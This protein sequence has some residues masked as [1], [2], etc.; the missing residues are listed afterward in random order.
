MGQATLRPV[1]AVALALG[2][3]AVAACAGDDSSNEPITIPS[4]AS[5]SAKPSSSASPALDALVPLPAGVK[6]VAD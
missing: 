4:T 5:T 2:A 3:L 1:A 6:V